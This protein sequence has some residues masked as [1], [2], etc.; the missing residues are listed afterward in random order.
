MTDDITVVVAEL[1]TIR[2]TAAD[3]RSGSGADPQDMTSHYA[4][5]PTPEPA[6]AGLLPIFAV[7]VIGFGAGIVALLSRRIGPEEH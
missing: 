5:H 3:D 1:G 6:G 4:E 2:R 7:A